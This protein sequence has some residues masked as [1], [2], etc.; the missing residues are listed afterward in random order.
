M[1]PGSHIAVFML[2]LALIGQG[3]SPGIILCRSDDGHFAVGTTMNPCCS[4]FELLIPESSGNLSGSE[5][6]QATH[7]DCGLCVDT[8]LPTDLFR[9][10]V[11]EFRTSADPARVAVISPDMIAS[12]SRTLFLDRVNPL[13]FA[14]QPVSTTNLLL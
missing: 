10:P 13:E 9:I 12:H 7:D 6:E 3:V 11:P 8:I 5:T 2:V 1:K 4:P 14:L